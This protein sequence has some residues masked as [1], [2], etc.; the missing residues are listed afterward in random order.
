MEITPTTQNWLEQ[1]DFGK[2]PETK[3]A[4]T[5]ADGLANK[6]VFLRLLSA[7]LSHQNPLNPADG[8][9]FVTQLAQFTEM[10]KMLAVKN[11]LV[12]I[13][14]LLGGMAENDPAGNPMSP[15]PKTQ[16]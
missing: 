3:K 10:E 9:Q 5:G 12:E 6:E 2:A 16:N 14:K 8:L 15:Q 13:H 7:Q 11:E 1:A 4:P